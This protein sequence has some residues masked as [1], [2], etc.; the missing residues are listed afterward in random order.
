MFKPFASVALGLVL[1][2]GLPVAHAPA[3]NLQKLKVAEVVRSQLFAPMY[4]AI[5]QSFFRD[6]GIELDLITA[7][8]GD[9]VGALVLSG[10]VD[11]GLAG[12]EVAI[13]LY[14][15]E[16]PDKPVLFCSV[17]GTDGFFFVSREKI[18]P[19]AWDKLKNRRIIGW[20]PGSTPQL[21]FEYILKQKGVDSE[22]I[23]SIVTNIAPPAREGAWLSGEG[24]FG[25]FNEPSTENLARAGRIHVLASIGKE[26]GA[27]E[28]T[29]FFAKKSW[30]EKNRDVAQKF[31]NSIARAQAWMK[32]ATEAQ[33]AAALAPHFPGLPPDIT[34]DVIKRYRG[35]GAPILSE[36]PQISRPGLAKLQEVMVIGGVIDP[37]KTVPYES[38]VAAEFA[39]EA[40]R[41]AL[42]K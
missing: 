2:L 22:T 5:N 31:T 15:S 11:L 21:F 12:P 41:S 17:N 7:N 42:P 34:V 6:Q 32:A 3:Q 29:D 18:E 37:G 13:Y 19:F 27:A 40:R 20:R 24:D 39:L 26:L 4:V 33:I 23:K 28:N 10:Q 1:T 38:I 30:I 9:R 8:G 16:A 35:T 14:N 36:T 25:I